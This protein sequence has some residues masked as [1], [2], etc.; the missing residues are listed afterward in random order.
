MD[1]STFFSRIGI[2]PEIAQDIMSVLFVAFVSFIYGMLVGR[3]RLIPALVNI[4]ASF[5]I[6]SVVPENMLSDYSSRLILFFILWGSLTIFSRK[7]FDIPFYGS[8]TSFLWRVF[9]M[10]FLQ[11]VLLLS[12][13]FSVV[14]RKTA[15]TYI[16]SSAYGYLT[17]GRA[18]L[19]W[20]ALPLVYLF[21]IYRKNR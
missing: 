16:S 7:F 3:Y 21:F 1:F 14:P 11:G 8:G 4:Y 6:T 9:S 13:A 17:E 19:V 2:S 5:A 15:L 12:I 20:M 10:S 18:P